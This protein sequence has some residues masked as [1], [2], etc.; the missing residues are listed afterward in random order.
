MGNLAKILAPQ[1]AV[2]T[3]VEHLTKTRM[4]NA[5]PKSDKNPLTLSAVQTM[6][7]SAEKESLES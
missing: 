1:M 4:T 7:A 6:S 5:V 2:A 3:F